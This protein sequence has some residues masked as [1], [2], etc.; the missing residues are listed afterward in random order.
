MTREEAIKILEVDQLTMEEKSANEIMLKFDK[1]MTNNQADKGGSY[2]IACKVYYA[3][4]FLMQDYSTELN[5]SQWNPN[6]AGVNE[7]EKEADEQKEEEEK[8][9]EEVKEK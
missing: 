2:Y 7:E 9:E 1:M 8:K 3:K 6:S 4:E 5:T